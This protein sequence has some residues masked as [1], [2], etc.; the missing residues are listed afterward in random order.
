MLI[1]QQ[2]DD[3]WVRASAVQTRILA[4]RE[5][6]VVLDPPGRQQTLATVTRLAPLRELSS[7]ELDWSTSRLLNTTPTA[8]LTCTRKEHQGS[9]QVC[10][11]PDE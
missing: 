8:Y 4:R 3:L 11:P 2:G 1:C 6:D 5:R 9:S 10:Q 7:T